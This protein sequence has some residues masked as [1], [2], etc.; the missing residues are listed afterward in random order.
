MRTKSKQNNKLKCNEKRVKQ[1]ISTTGTSN[2][3]RKID[4]TR[5]RIACVFVCVYVCIFS[6][7]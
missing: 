7:T 6:C 5:D 1:A 2:T 4:T 3:T